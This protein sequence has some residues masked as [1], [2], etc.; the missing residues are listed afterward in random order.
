MEP[1]PVQPSPPANPPVPAEPPSFEQPP[2]EDLAGLQKKM[3]ELRMQRMTEKE[4]E[5]RQLEAR[6]DKKISNFKQFVEATEMQGR[7]LAA[8]PAPTVE[9]QQKASALKLLEG[10]GLNPFG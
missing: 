3:D 10:T 7:S 4:M 8:A 2:E 5:L 1:A 9:E 6:I